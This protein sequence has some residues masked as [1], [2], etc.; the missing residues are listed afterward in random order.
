MKKEHA[1]RKN[2][3]FILRRVIQAVCFILLPSLF[4]QIF[5]SMKTVFM[6]I[7]HGQ[8]TFAAAMPSLIILVLATVVTAI[9]GRFFCGWMCAFGSL[10]DFLYRMPRLNSKKL[11]KA[12]SQWDKIFKYFKYVVLAIFITFVWGFQILAIPAG[13]NPW[14][15]FGML[16][17]FGN[18]PPLSELVSGWLPAAILLIAI[19][20]ISIFIER[21]FC[22]YIC[23]VGAY[24][25]IIS[26]VRALV[27]K[28]PRE[29]CG[30]CSLCTRK[31]SMA[32]N[33]GK[34]DSVHSGECINCMECT[35][36]C[37]NN[38]AHIE[39]AGQNLNAMV[40]GTLSCAVIAGAYYLGNFAGTQVNAATST[41]YAQDA[42]AAASG[43][44]AGLADGTYTGSGTGFRGE[45]TVSVEVYD[46]IITGITIESTNDDAEYI[47]KAA[48]TIISEIISSQ[49]VDVDAVSGATYSS[50]GIREAV[51]DAL[52]LE[53]TPVQVQ[54]GGRHRRYGR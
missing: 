11:H 17:S 26:R 40:A 4:I 8:G 23:P 29:K 12:P 14:D 34:M 9:A 50:N 41:A 47:N 6:L 31:C 43:I 15:L 22:R 16:V 36:C 46:G 18:W 5:N 48:S 27:V 7:F 32:I 3:I 13:T 24:F 39:I 35:V 51:A 38:N 37:P 54:E 44:A 42:G 10:S 2:V 30:K 20:V 45:T 33:L 1:G 19:M 53:N 25:S 52:G 28:K 21:F 49:S